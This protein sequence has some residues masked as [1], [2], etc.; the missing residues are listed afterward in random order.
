MLANARIP[1]KRPSDF[2]TRLQDT[3]TA[4]R[5]VRVDDR[6][7]VTLL[8]NEMMAVEADGSEIFPSFAVM[9]L[10]LLNDTAFG[11]RYEQRPLVFNDT[12]TLNVDR[13]TTPIQR[14]ID[15]MVNAAKRVG[16]IRQADN[17]AALRAQP[18]LYADYPFVYQIL[19]NVILQRLDALRGTV[20]SSALCKYVYE[21][22]WKVTTSTLR[23]LNNLERDAI[24]W[25]TKLQTG[26]QLT[27]TQ[28]SS[29][30]QNIITQ[31][32][33]QVLPLFMQEAHDN[34]NVAADASTADDVVPQQPQQ[35]QRR[36]AQPPSTPVRPRQ[37]IIK[38]EPRPPTPEPSLQPET[39][40]ESDE[41]ST[42]DALLDAFAL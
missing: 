7:K 37:P 3:L 22:R 9:Q 1:R 23:L 21:Q 2:D 5:H 29:T 16:D 41:G 13:S 35:Q 8:E 15:S 18:S 12:G 40:E 42:I 4:L 28:S 27:R 38:Q 30:I 34:A 24:E 25:S 10:Y 6:G 33:D 19:R 31:I 32:I 39:G 14:M 17:A 26:N 11:A 20:V 36:P